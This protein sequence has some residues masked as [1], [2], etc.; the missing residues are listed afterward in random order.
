MHSIPL[1]LG[2]RGAR[3]RGVTEN[4]IGAFD[5]ALGQG[6]DGFEFDVRLT[7]DHAAVICHNPRSRGRAISKSPAERLAHLDSLNNVLAKYA[8]RAFLDIELKVPGLEAVV[9]AALHNYPPARGYVVSSFLP[10]VLLELRKQDGSVLL[11]L[12]CD[13]KK[14]LRLWRE[15]AIDYVI[16]HYS[17][18]TPKLVREIQ[19]SGKKILVWTVNRRSLMLRLA[20]WGVHGI[21]SDSPAPLVKTLRPKT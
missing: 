4:T 1:L 15:L 2:H 11:G 6:C 19:D 17:L 9:L 5:L 20:H 16:P 10:Q 7:R 12:I 3:A 18:I 13:K 14:Q 8:T 21:I